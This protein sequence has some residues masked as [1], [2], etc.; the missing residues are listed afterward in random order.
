MKCW[1]NECLFNMFTSLKSITWKSKPFMWRKLFISHIYSHIFYH[2]VNYP[3]VNC[4]L[5]IDFPCR[6]QHWNS[7]KRPWLTLIKKSTTERNICPYT[8]E[9]MG[10]ILLCLVPVTPRGSRPHVLHVRGIKARRKNQ[11]RLQIMTHRCIAG[12]LLWTEAS[13]EWCT[14]DK[15]LSSLAI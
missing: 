13:S 5:L 14:R 4:A 12:D 11:Y 1:L 7:A 8:P 3:S 9:E 10:S 6:S 15:E 2:P